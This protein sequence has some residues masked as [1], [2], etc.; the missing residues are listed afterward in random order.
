MQK[1]LVQTVPAGYERAAVYRCNNGI[2]YTTQAEDGLA[3]GH[4]LVQDLSANMAQ[5]HNDQRYVLSIHLILQSV[6]IKKLTW[7]K[8]AE[9]HWELER[10]FM[11][12]KNP[13]F[14]K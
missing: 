1:T 9:L 10:I 4:Q 14:E 12:P 11:R 8:R 5:T 2:R 7:D 13:G 6:V 3:I